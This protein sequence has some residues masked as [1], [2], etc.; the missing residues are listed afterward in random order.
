MQCFQWFFITVLALF[1]FYAVLPAWIFLVSCLFHSLI[2]FSPFFFSVRGGPSVS[3]SFCAVLSMWK[4]LGRGSRVHASM[5]PRIHESK[6]WNILWVHEARVHWSTDPS[7]PWINCPVWMGF[8]FHPVCCRLHFAYCVRG[9]KRELALC[10][11]FVTD[12]RFHERLT[13]IL[14]VFRL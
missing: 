7:G 1:R 9:L 2:I 12:L 10:T 4:F 5:S 6:S 3:L 14:V 8:H 11:V 13:S